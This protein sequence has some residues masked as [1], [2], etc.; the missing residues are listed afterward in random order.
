MVASADG[1]Y[2]AFSLNNLQEIRELAGSFVYPEDFSLKDW[3][4]PRWGMEFGEPLQVKVRFINRSQTF[5]KVRK[6]LAHRHCILREEN[7]G[8]TLLYEDTVIGK[9][10]F[11]AW[12]LGFGSAA[13]VLEP[14]TLRD[15][16]TA[17]VRATLA[18]YK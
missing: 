11:I 3:L 15:D 8:E 13:E 14:Q 9:N 5:A 16:I 10:E 1:I 17:R 7:G 4:A 12:L 18:N 2:K 6:D